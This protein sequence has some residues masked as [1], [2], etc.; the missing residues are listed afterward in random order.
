MV[1]TSLAKVLAARRHAFNERVK[2]TRHAMPGFDTAAFG[3]FVTHEIDAICVAVDAV[4][5]CASERVVEAAFDIGLGLVAQ[6]LAGPAARLPWV[7]QAWRALSVPAARLMA[8]APNDA[9]ALVTNAV[10][11]LASVPGVRV[12]DWIDGMASLVERCDTLES[13]RSLGAVCAWRAG[14]AHLRR[15]AL[16][17]GD[18]LPPDLAAAAVGVPTAT[19]SSLREPLQA[20]RWWQPAQGE[21]DRQ[22]WTVGGFSGLGGHFG[23]PPEVR[24]RGDDFVVESA[25]R[26]FLV[27]ADGFGAVVLPASAAEFADGSS[28]D[29]RDLSMTPA[30]PRI[31][32][33]VIRFAAPPD[34]MQ[35]VASADSVALFSPWSHLIRI[36]PANP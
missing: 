6:G 28:T 16:E 12:G 20:M 23:A 3:V 35:A 10:V 26:H 29:A 14:M 24:V 21:V 19:W 9:L 4:D 15:S 2:E 27:M 22:G 31:N 18:R 5:A 32:D 8:V 13:L 30:G 34:R 7:N 36:V 25:G 11:R 33:T 17:H 1:S